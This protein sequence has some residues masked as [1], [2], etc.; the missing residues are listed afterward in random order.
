MSDEQ[1][2]ERTKTFL[3]ALLERSEGLRAM[4]R[5]ALEDA[6]DIID[7]RIDPKVWESIERLR[8]GDAERTTG[9]TVNGL[10]AVHMAIPLA[11]FLLGEGLEMKG[12]EAGKYVSRP[13]VAE[14][15]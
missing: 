1:T 13:R 4:R 11:H 2:P 8:E 10:Q 5:Q 7:T 12:P 14:E 3:D 6:F 15:S 9:Y